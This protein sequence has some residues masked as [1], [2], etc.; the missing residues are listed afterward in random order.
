MKIS[1][2]GI[3]PIIIR[4]AFLRF[5]VDLF[6]FHN[7]GFGSSSG[8]LFGSS[9]TTNGTSCCDPSSSRP[10]TGRR[11]SFGK[12]FGQWR[13][14]LCVCL[15]TKPP[16]EVWFASIIKSCSGRCN[17]RCD[18]RIEE[19]IL[20]YLTPSRVKLVILCLCRIKKLVGGCSQQHRTR[21]S[22]QSFTVQIR[23]GPCA[24][25]SALRTWPC[26]H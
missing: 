9:S 10:S 11:R 12:P 16:G 17:R 1:I 26:R 24:G 19:R 5:C 4:S 22:I 23:C 13:F 25:P 20:A 21:M 18:R 3:P 8:E 7:M 14:T 6:S 15:R 2:P